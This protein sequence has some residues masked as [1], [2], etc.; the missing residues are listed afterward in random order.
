MTA[1]QIGCPPSEVHTYEAGSS[2]GFIQSAESWIAECRGRRFVCTEVTTSSNDI[3]WIFTD[4]TDSVDSDVACREELAPAN[5][6]VASGA[7]NAA[8]PAEEIAQSA[9]PNSAAGFEF[10][11]ERSGAKASCESAGHTWSEDKTAHATCS[12][13][14]TGTGFAATTKLTFCTGSLCGITI[15]HVPES[16]W[17]DSF[18]DI[19]SALTA[20][21][22][23][24]SARRVLIPTMCR[25]KEQF[26]RCATD[27]TLALQVSWHWAAGQRV[28]LFL[29][30]PSPHTGDAAVQLTYV[31]RS[32]KSRADTS[33]L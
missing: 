10:G 30:K 20:K 2:G 15:S 12:G 1:G 4:S 6:T 11:I 17:A 3:T 16:N 9:P 28:K 19:D 21:Y 32:R 18:T 24:A 7:A 5:L 26:D 8:N 25:S 33:A 14:A 22:G 31:Q 29:G 23:T 13:T 27:G